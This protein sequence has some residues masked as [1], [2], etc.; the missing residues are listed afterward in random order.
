[1]LSQNL[2]GASQLAY[3]FMC[4]I[5]LH[6]KGKSNIFSHRDSPHLFVGQ[7]RGGLTQKD[8]P[9]S[10]PSGEYYKQLVISKAHCFHCQLCK[11]ITR[12]LEKSS[13]VEVLKPI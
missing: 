11:G 9:S 13:A 7:H 4:S 3:I 8:T 2:A 6:S 1:V 5:A 10:G 12:C